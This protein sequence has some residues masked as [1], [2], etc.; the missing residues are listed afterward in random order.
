VWLWLTSFL[1]LD[2]V[3]VMGT[4]SDDKGNK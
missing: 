1:M 4:E 2:Q 3:N